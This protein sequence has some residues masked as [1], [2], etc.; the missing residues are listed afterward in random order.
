MLSVGANRTRLIIRLAGG[1]NM[2]ISAS[3]SQ[4]FNIGT[5]NIESART[6]LNRLKMPI[7]ASEVGGQT[8]RTIRIYVATSRVTVRVIG[9]KEHDL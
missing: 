9:E 5:R 2:L 3:L 6:T 4:T 8:G 1:A 7:T